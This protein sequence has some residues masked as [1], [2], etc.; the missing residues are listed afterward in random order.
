[1]PGPI[2]P[3]PAD[4]LAGIVKAYDIRGICPDELDPSAA[5][6]I[7]YAFAE[8]SGATQLVL[9]RDMRPSGVSLADAFASGAQAAGVDV[10]DIGLAST[11]LLYFASGH[12]D[13]P[14]AMLTASHNPAA[15]NGI[16]LCGPGAA[17]V[18][19]NSGLADIA[20]R[21]AQGAA[22]TAG[23]GRR[24]SRDLLDTFAIHVRSFVD[25]E[26]LAPLRVVADTANGMGGHVLPAVF[27]PLPFEWE[28]MYG[29]LDGTFPNHPADPIRPENLVDLSK[30]VLE[31]GADVGLAFDGDAD[32]VFLTDERG[33]AVSGSLLTALVAQ[34]ML[35]RC[36]PGPILYNLICSRAVPEA[37][38]EAGG[39]P[40]RTRV[41][42]SF[43]KTEM[44]RTGAAFGGEHSGHYYFADN[45]RADSGL[46]A[47]LVA[48]EQLSTAAVP[49]SELLAPLDRYASS[50]EINTRVGDIDEVLR[51]VS[52]RFTR[53]SQDRLD[54]LTVDAGDWWFNLR[55]SNTE[56]LLRLNLEALDAEAVAERVSEIRALLA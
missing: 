8:W 19:A 23:G 47:A 20:Q 15:Y 33:R 3:V 26:S 50:G 44:A 32:R 5:R 1:M 55:P 48:L 37:I 21:A 52:A 28:L 46:I 27:G 7:G 42:H 29:E 43:I 53:Y 10:I 13:L 45:Y 16:K 4:V 25:V 39:Q 40:L 36:G 38:A 2:D 49:L 14:G 6:G 12:L 30:R 35:R 17:P 18:G 24:H 54:G 9:G 31:V 51:R 56:P 41:G 34:A 22:S 11:D